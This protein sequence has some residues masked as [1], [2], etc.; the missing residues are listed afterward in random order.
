MTHFET[1]VLIIGCGISGATA[2][3]RLAKDPH[4][5]ITIVTP[6]EDP[7]ESNTYYA[8][9]GIIYRGDDDSP[10]LL[11]GDIERAG[12]GL[13]NPVAVRI[14]AEEGPDLVRNLLVDK[15]G[16][17]FDNEP[18]HG[19]ERIKEAAHSTKRIIH[20]G[21]YTG[22]AI[23]EKLV[24]ALRSCP[25]ITLLPK[26]TAVD[27]LTTSHH[28]RNR[29][30]VY[31][32]LCCVGAYLFEQTT[33]RVR[34]CLARKTLLAT[35]GLGRIFLYSTNPP[36]ARGDGLAMAYNA[37]AR[38]INAEFVQFHPTAFYY[39]DQARFLV[40]EAVRGAGAKL[41]ND[42]GE[43]FM[44]KYA[45]E[46][47]D[48]APRD[49]V[50]RSIHQEMLTTGSPCV[51]LDLKSYLSADKITAHF[52]AI[53]QK[54]LEFGVD[55]T[56]DWI[57]VVPAAHYHCGGVWVDE[58]GRST[59]RNLYAVGE[60]SCTGVHGA[61]RLGSASLLEGLVWGARAAEDAQRTLDQDCCAYVDIPPW[62]DEGLTL[63]ADPALIQQ[64]M[65][66]IQHIMWNYVGL[67]R[68]ARRLDRAI[69]DLRNLQV[70]ITR[71]YGSTKLSDSLIGLRNAVQ[72]ALIISQAAWENKVSQGCHYR[73]D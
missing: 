10:E 39:R 12:A 61:N 3:L 23:Q 17:P 64:D 58:Y 30:A 28:S 8:Q 70:D 25:N 36:A 56:R 6:E 49:V 62:Y 38:I 21:D 34:A 63:T 60:V 27:L 7:R 20:V 16:V 67:V 24:E 13:S 45:P 35:G 44:H 41:V 48:L 57:P 32:P 72:V 5:R 9:G 31:E 46:W 1:D 22:R 51:Y 47:L 53:Y 11:I 43:P 40:S 2:A 18:G 65:A 29:L 26:T 66:N 59:V 42:R 52:P 55:I 73:E 4:L 71:F 50:A 68:S 15:L 14:L 19:M 54:C 37:G 33:G 69:S